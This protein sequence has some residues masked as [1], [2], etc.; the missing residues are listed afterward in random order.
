MNDDGEIA[1]GGGSNAGFNEP[2]EAVTAKSKSPCF[3]FVCTKLMI[4]EN[5][6]FEVEY[7]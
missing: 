5:V 6:A 2:V 7:Y 4:V 3:C 1:S